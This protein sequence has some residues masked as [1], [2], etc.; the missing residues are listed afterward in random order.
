VAYAEIVAGVRDSRGRLVSARTAA[1]PVTGNGSLRRPSGAALLSRAQPVALG[2]GFIGSG[3]T[4][5]RRWIGRGPAMVFPAHTALV[6]RVTPKAPHG[7]A[8]KR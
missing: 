1:R 5:Y 6:I 4:I 2:L 3:R 8:L 7:P